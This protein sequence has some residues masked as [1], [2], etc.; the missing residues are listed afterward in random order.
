LLSG[1]LFCDFASGRMMNE[2]THKRIKT[3]LPEMVFRESVNFIDSVQVRIL[4]W[5]ISTR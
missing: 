2:N 4:I 5:D 3:V 1:A